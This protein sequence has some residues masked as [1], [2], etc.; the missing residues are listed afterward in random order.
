MNKWKAQKMQKHKNIHI[1][2][3]HCI[4]EDWELTCGGVGGRKEGKKPWFKPNTTIKERLHTQSLIQSDVCGHIWPPTDNWVSQCLL[5]KPDK[6]PQKA[7]VNWASTATLVWHTERWGCIY[8]I[9]T[10]KMRLPLGLSIINC[11][12][13]RKL[14]QSLRPDYWKHSDTIT[15]PHLSRTH[16]RLGTLRMCQ[17]LGV[18]EGYTTAVLNYPHKSELMHP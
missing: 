15:S 7:S 8:T 17:H 4:L 2:E 10:S 9:H 1:V 14:S 13:T 16:S 3:R 12:K 18:A 5:R 6:C 11:T